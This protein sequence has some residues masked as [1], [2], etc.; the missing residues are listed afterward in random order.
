MTTAPEE[1]QKKREHLRHVTGFAIAGGLAFLVDAGVLTFAVSALD[2]R[3]EVARVPSFLAAVVTTWLINRRYTFRTSRAPSLAE[4]LRYLWAMSV[5]LA[6]NYAVFVTV[7]HLSD[8]A[9]AL[10]V[11]ALVPATLSGMVVNFLT[12]R[13]ILHK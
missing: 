9:A 7:L 12:S 1:T 11:L 6:V 2:L 4:F 10:P 13:R 5:G 8:T 3:P